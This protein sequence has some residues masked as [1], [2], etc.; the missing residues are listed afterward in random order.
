MDLDK[1]GFMNAVH[2]LDRSKGLDLLLHTPGG[3]FAATE[4]IVHYL[5]QMFGTN[6]RC[7]IP[8][9]AMSGGT[10]IA[11]A[12]RE[13]YMG[14]ESNIGPIDPQFGGIPAHGVIAEFKKAVE[15]ISA[16]PQSIPLWQV[17]IAK[18]HPTF[19]G[20][21]QNAIDLAT[22]IVTQ[23]LVSGMFEGDKDANATA[24]RI[25]G[26]LNNHADTKMHARHIHADEALGFGLKITMLE[27]DKRLQDT[28]L[29]VHHAYMH[30]FASS[31]AVKIVENHL[32]SAI[33]SVAR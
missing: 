11:C 9:L 30:T 3:D 32:G 21:C 33:V 22:A 6:I 5:R 14:R 18:Y 28:V 7:F 29:T 4:S 20:E 26:K 10:M 23:W 8:Q 31:Q 27:T 15:D 25:V 1:N 16:N 19:I 2:K 24:K 17:I 12:S 13:I